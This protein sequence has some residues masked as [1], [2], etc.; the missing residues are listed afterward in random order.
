[1]S[2]IRCYGELNTDTK[3]IWYINPLYNEKGFIYPFL[4][5]TDNKCLALKS[6][7]IDEHTPIINLTLTDIDDDIF[8]K[9][10]PTLLMIKNKDKKSFFVKIISHSGIYKSIIDEPSFLYK[11]VY[12]VIRKLGFSDK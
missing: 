12:I 5:S 8:E 6:V 11:G 4:Y 10:T 7:W 3:N 9:F 2:L 1:M